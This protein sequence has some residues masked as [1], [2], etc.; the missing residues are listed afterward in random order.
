M[1]LAFTI[2]CLV[3][4]LGT[5]AQEPL[6]PVL[7]E[8]DSTALNA[9]TDM[10]YR[11]FPVGISPPGEFMQPFNMPELNLDE[12]LSEYQNP[13]LADYSFDAWHLNNFYPRYF[14]ISPAPFLRNG[15][16]FSQG[17]YQLNDKFRLGGY[18]FGGNSIFSAPFP[19]QNTG[20]F[21]FRG[22]TLFM[23]YK[24]SDKFKIETKVSVSQGR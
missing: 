11:Q 22:S 1:K 17:S 8:Q 4:I 6:M 9:E 20:N 24:V 13:G 7:S 5:T 19:N 23:E 14:G 12:A 18:S 10:L 3:I 21:D 16:V 2:F 15:T